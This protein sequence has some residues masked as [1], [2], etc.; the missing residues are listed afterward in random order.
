M[1][2]LHWLLVLVGASCY[3]F[4]FPFSFRFFLFYVCLLS[5]MLRMWILVSWSRILFVPISCQPH[6][7]SPPGTWWRP[8]PRGENLRVW[9]S[10]VSGWFNGSIVITSVVMSY[11][12]G[13][14]SL[15]PLLCLQRS[16]DNFS[17]LYLYLSRG[18]HSEFWYLLLR[19]F[20]FFSLCGIVVI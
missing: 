13:S 3:E 7:P 4:P 12:S 15:C 9:W 16:V 2:F 19:P 8:E 17:Y 11:F 5:G 14:I 18:S 1:G 10:W 6:T 20:R